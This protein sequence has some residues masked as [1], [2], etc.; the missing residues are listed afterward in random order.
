MDRVTVKTCGGLGNILFQVA[1]GF[2]YSKRHNKEFVL[3]QNMDMGSSHEGIDAYYNTILS[4]I[5]K[6]FKLT[7]TW[8][9]YNQPEFKYEE[10][11]FV[12]GNVILSGYFQSEKYFVEYKKDIKD[13][14][15]I[16][17]SNNSLCSMSIRRGDYLKHANYHTNLSVD[18]YIS[19]MNKLN[20]KKYSIVSDDIE[21]CRRTFKG[22][23]FDFIDTSPLESLRF[24]M[25]CKYSIIANSTFSW[26]GAWLG[27]D[28]TTVLAPSNWF[29]KDGPSDTQDLVAKSW[30]VI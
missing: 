4:E 14:F 19:A 17:Y 22:S 20:L 12:D 24:M 7:G 25:S 28:K 18:Y 29:G 10:I 23:E 15:D 8:T 11:P 5:N 30:I 21:W 1:A 13:L 2:A 9:Q 3:F 6:E 26:W 27:Q 16:G